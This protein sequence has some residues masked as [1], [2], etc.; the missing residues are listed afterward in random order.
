MARGI[1]KTC[2]G[3]GGGEK[4]HIALRNQDGKGTIVWEVASSQFA[5]VSSVTQ[6][7]PV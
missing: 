4:G 1:N 2:E 3:R 7:G 6:R 5:R